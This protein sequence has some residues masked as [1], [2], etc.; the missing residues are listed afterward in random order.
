[1]AESVY[2]GVSYGGLQAIRIIICAPVFGWIG[3]A[4]CVEFVSPVEATR[5]VVV[6]VNPLV[7]SDVSVMTV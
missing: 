5:S 1:M 3:I 2:T 4:C 7:L 6:E